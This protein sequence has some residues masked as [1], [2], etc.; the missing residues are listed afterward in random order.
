M[1]QFWSFLWTSS[2][3][4]TAD[5]L[6]PAAHDGCPFVCVHRRTCRR[7]VAAEL[8]RAVPATYDRRESALRRLARPG[9]V[10]YHNKRGAHPDQQ[11]SRGIGPT[12][13]CE[14]RK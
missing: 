10:S 12:D 14:R 4:K 13:S 11:Q 6:S 1:S 2:A 5:E 8:D 7:T 9:V 3:A